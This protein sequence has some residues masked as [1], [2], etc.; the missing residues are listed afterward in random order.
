MLA[1]FCLLLLIVHLFACRQLVKRL[2]ELLYEERRARLRASAGMAPPPVTHSDTCRRRRHSM[3]VSGNVRQRRRSRRMSLFLLPFTRQPV[4]PEDAPLDQQMD[5]EQDN[6]PSISRGCAAAVRSARNSGGHASCHAASSS[7]EHPRRSGSLHGA[8]SVLNSGH[9]SAA[10]AG[11]GTGECASASSNSNVVMSAGGLLASS[12][13]LSRLK[14]AG[15][16]SGS[17][18]MSAPALVVQAGAAGAAAGD[19]TEWFQSF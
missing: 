14:G 4:V 8:S 5:E 19:G 2:N 18:G 13:T 11:G 17:R 6:N 9:S 1:L 16:V 7:A 15:G 3:P 12:S 10:A